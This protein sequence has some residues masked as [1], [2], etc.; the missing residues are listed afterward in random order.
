MSI[1]FTLSGDSSIFSEN[2]YPPIELERG[3]QYSLGLVSFTSFNSVPNIDKRVFYYEKTTAKGTV[4]KKEIPTGSYEIE[5]LEQYLK[6]AVGADNISLKPNLNTLK[7]E[8]FSKMYNIDFGPDD[9]LH[10]ILG[11]SQRKLM[12]GKGYKSDLPIKIIKVLTIHINCNITTG[13]YKNNDLVHSLHEFSLDVP[14]GFLIREQPRNIIYMPVSV[15]RISNITLKVVDQDGEL[16]N[17]RGERIE[18][19]LELKRHGDK[20]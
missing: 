13:S 5:D 12:A 8:I 19:R 10:N 17:F 20:F 16:I 9:S 15:D 6:S 18:I 4:E 1:T 2:Y 7:C 3:V 11:F 14:P